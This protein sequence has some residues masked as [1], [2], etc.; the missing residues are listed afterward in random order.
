MIYI[1]KKCI[2]HDGFSIAC[3]TNNLAFAE[4]VFDIE[5]NKTD[6]IKGYEWTELVCFDGQKHYSFDG[7][8]ILKTTY[9]ER[10]FK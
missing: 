5:S 1:V 10:D 3:A 2:A 7:G 9:V 6:L 4:D 8:N